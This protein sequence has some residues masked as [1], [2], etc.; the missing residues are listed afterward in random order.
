MAALSG[1]QPQPVLSVAA[2]HPMATGLQPLPP[3]G[4]A[5][6]PQFIS[7]QATFLALRGRWFDSGVDILYEDGRPF[8]H[9]EHHSRR[10]IM[11]DA[12]TN[13]LLCVLHKGRRRDG[14]PYYA[15]LSPDPN[16]PR[17]L[18]AKTIKHFLSGDDIDM[19]FPNAVNEGQWITLEFTNEALFG[20]RG[21]VT[22]NRVPVAVLKKSMM[23]FRREYRI[24]V[25]P[26]MDMFVVAVLAIVLKEKDSE[27]EGALLAG[28][29]ASG[30]GA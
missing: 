12:T 15:Q 29:A 20:V 7:Q 24:E 19:Q 18:E 28:G 10:Y 13:T 6:F 23:K 21:E 4:L 27:Q 11:T 16:S 14:K 25:A 1:K 17:I 9:A 30:A 26:G 8:I 2:P 22:Y 3:P 5:V